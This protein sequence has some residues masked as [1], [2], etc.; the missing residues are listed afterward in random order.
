M[1]TVA[2]VSKKPSFLSRCRDAILKN[3]CTILFFW[4]AYTRPKELYIVGLS[5]LRKVS[6][7]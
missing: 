5:P 6:R 1:V 7:L 3:E 2:Q 4:R